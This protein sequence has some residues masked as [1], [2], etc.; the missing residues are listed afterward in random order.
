[1]CAV[2]REQSEQHGET[3][4]AEGLGLWRGQGT[5]VGEEV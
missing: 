3:E 2:F 5:V 1:M 4:I